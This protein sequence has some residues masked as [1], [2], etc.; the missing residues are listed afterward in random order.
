[1]HTRS[2]AAG[3]EF[4]VSSIWVF[5]ITCSTL[6]GGYEMAEIRHNI[7]HGKMHLID[8][9][10]KEQWAEGVKDIPLQ[11]EHGC[12]LLCRLSTRWSLEVAKCIL[13]CLL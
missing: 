5:R 11:S 3:V 4:S 13:Q 7:F 12:S 10:K 8:Q 6:Y 1:M 9:V 2:G